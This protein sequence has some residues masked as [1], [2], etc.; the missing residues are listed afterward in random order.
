[1]EETLLQLEHYDCSP[2]YGYLQ[3]CNKE[4]KL[5]DDEISAKWEKIAE[6]LPELAHTKQ[7]RQEVEKLPSLNVDT[8]SGEQKIIM[9]TIL[10]MIAAVYLWLDG[11]DVMDELPEN[12]SSALWDLSKEIGVRPVQSYQNLLNSVKIDLDFDGDIHDL[13]PEDI[14][15][16]ISTR[17]PLPG[18]DT[19]PNFVKCLGLSEL[20]AAKVYAQFPQILANLHNVVTV[21]ECLR[22]M[23]AALVRSQ[24]VFGLIHKYC[25]TEIFYNT[26][27]V[28]FTGYGM[29]N[30]A[31]VKGVRFPG[32][33]ERVTGDGAGANQ[34]CMF[35]CLD[36]F[37]GITHK[38][39]SD[40]LSK[41][42]SY[43]LPK[44]LKLVDDIAELKFSDYVHK[45]NDLSLT[46]A[47]SALVKELERHRSKHMGI[48]YRFLIQEARKNG[49][50][51][52]EKWVGTGGGHV[53]VLKDFR[54]DTSDK[55]KEITKK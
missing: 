18:G 48:V 51:N 8:L 7:L 17:Y 47:F 5:A 13:E 28:Y 2:D 21:T 27:R 39:Q 23:K 6:R 30:T 38:S 46:E 35:H 11:N 25:D 53:N 33:S 19:S 24:L 10:N 32:V 3:Y 41:S 29:H 50:T 43:L 14:F 49:E 54:Q 16:R 15:T 9:Q 42:R 1:M 4:A 26:I 52:S 44:Q 40:F 37:L 20:F 45:Q 55:H 22:H 36:A 12:L 31:L 34:A